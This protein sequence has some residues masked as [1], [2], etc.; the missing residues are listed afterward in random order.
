MICLKCKKEMPDG[1]LFCPWCG[2]AQEVKAKKRKKRKNANGFGSVYFNGVSWVAERTLGYKTF[3]IDGKP[4]KKRLSEKKKGFKTSRDANL[5]LVPLITKG[6]KK[7]IDTMALLHT[8]YTAS[9][10]YKKL[11]SKKGAYKKAWERMKPIHN[12]PVDIVTIQDLRDLVE[13]LNYY[14]AKDIKDLTSNLYKIAV[15]E[16]QVQTNLAPFIELP[17]LDA[18]ETVPWNEQEI[19]I[20]WRLYAKGNRIAMA[21]LIMIYSGMMPGELFICEE[22]MINYEEHTITGCGLK[23]KKRKETPIVFPDFVSPVLRDLASTSP[24]RIGRILGM[25]EDNFYAEFKALKEGNGIR[26]AIRPY[27]G[28]HSTQT[29]LAVKNVAPGVIVEIMRQKNY[30]TSLDHYNNIQ[31]KDLVAALNQL[32]QPELESSEG[33][34]GE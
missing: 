11:G 15:A 28:R 32:R 13:G 2:V 26:D 25:A 34:T 20:L 31:T 21:C 10:K 8:I 3:I 30:K 24:S 19:E 16:G 17:E 6:K 1:A 14:P 7:I 27:S 5:Y 29:A 33:V 22:H 9:Q 23:T 12:I 4:K 18:E